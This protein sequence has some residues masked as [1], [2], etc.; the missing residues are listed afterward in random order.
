[1]VSK[2][3]S[4]RVLIV[5]H[6]AREHVIGESLVRGGAD[7][8]AFMS[9]RNAGLED[10]SKSIKIHSETDFKEIID[11]CSEMNIDFV[12]I[13]P[14]APLVVG[15]VDALER[16]EI[17]CI[18]PKIEAAQLE[19]S[20]VFTRGL[21]EK[22]KIRSNIQSKMFDS[23]EGLDKFI[24]S[25]G[26]ENIV[27]KPDGLT[28]GKGVKI[29][30]DHLF[31]NQEILDYCQEL[32]D[33]RS[34]FIIEE[35]CDGE[36]FTL[37]TFVD[38]KNVIGTPL[39]QDHKR[40][41][42]DDTG[43]NCYS[44]D[45][46]ILTETGWKTFD[47]LNKGEKVMTFDHEKRILEFQK[48]EKIHWMKYNGEMIH[49]EHRELDLLVTPNHRM[50]VKNRKS[51]KIEVLEAGSL[52]GE[53]E[54]FLTGIW[55]GE[56][57]E[58]FTIDEYD[59]KFN[60]KR[61]KQEIKLTDWIQF[62]GLYLSEGYVTDTENEHR[63]YICQTKN[64][65]YFKAF[66]K[67][68]SKLPF[69]NSYREEDSKFR[70]NSIQ[71]VN[72]LKEFGK[73]KEKFIPSY[74]KNGKKEHIIEFL[75]AFLL[76]DGNIH[77]GKKRF[78]SS[79]KKLIDDIQEL[80]LKIGKS[81]IITVDKRKKMLNPLNKKY[82]DV[83]EVYSVEIKPEFKV[84]IRKKDI[85]R[86][87]YQGYVG[88]VTVPTGFV[89][90]RRNNRVAISGNTGG[91]GSY[92]ME[93]H[94]MPFISQSDVNEA[95]ADMKKTVAAVKS[96]TGVEY[97]GFLYGQ[98]M[99]TA[100]GIKLIE[101]NSR[102]GD[103][104]AINVLPLLKGNFVDICW[105]I[106]NGNLTKNFEF[107]KKATVCKYLAPEGYPISPKQDELIKVDKKKLIEIGARYYYASVYRKE[108]NIY[109]TS[110]RA[111]GVLGIAN[112]LEEAEKIAEEGVGCIKGK[113]FHRNDVGTK[114]ILQKRID[115]MNLLLRT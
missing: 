80:I 15:I 93:D 14:E 24:K 60:R 37:Q 104:E 114:K 85:K 54:I 40:A 51:E 87:D 67:I 16:A 105:A 100:S 88:C 18:G 71:L 49:F 79:S 31:S 43:P 6:G 94:L 7:L 48:P 64:S 17:P 22:Y 42:E 76:G 68:L 81:S 30:G 72:I 3:G 38:G 56:S 23:M 89:V 63:V 36:E 59:F 69:K 50:L 92:S 34:R 115:H 91:M 32:I 99:K 95:L 113:L 57:P 5:G 28:G 55:E 21:L 84:G 108:G 44:S 111:I 58:Y 98:F 86:V 46:E 106:I 33:Q 2:M 10:L 74:I 109:T 52:I 8:F 65:K 78:F 9:F 61:E 102:L 103:P 97:K 96:E 27:V 26:E 75:N 77:N 45:T 20:K 82:Y 25:M 83:S 47:K 41:Y 11:Y 73:A 101:F 39:V 90:I 4:N 112:S 19:G 1:M 110:S 66:E 12:V 29:Y 35:K 53:K 107:E 13:G 70:I 62:M